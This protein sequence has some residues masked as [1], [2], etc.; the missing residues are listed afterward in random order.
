MF[1]KT[2]LKCFYDSLRGHVATEWF[3]QS[4]AETI[5]LSIYCRFTENDSLSRF[6]HHLFISVKSKQCDLL[7]SCA[8]YLSVVVLSVRQNKTFE[9]VTT[10]TSRK[11][12]MSVLPE[13]RES[14]VTWSL[15]WLFPGVHLSKMWFR[16]H[17]GSN[18]RL[19]VRYILSSESISHLQTT[20][21]FR[22]GLEQ[23][24]VHGA[25]RCLMLVYKNPHVALWK[26]LGSLCSLVPG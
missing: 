5:R 18:R 24:Q 3:Y 15:C 13:L 12:L 7:L 23:K 16:V 1:G 10:L 22:V 2:S 6:D 26:I 25:V 17:R 19:Q 20:W 11:I 4:G 9:Y 8:C 21:D 14:S